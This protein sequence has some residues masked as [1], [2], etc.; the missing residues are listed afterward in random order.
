[1]QHEALVAERDL[2]VDDLVEELRL[3]LR[4]DFESRLTRELR[5]Q[6]RLVSRDRQYERRR[7]LTAAG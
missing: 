4:K 2:S 5:V 6:M 1:M 7:E 3:A